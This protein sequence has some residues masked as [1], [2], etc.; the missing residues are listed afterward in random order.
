MSE[1]ENL[2]KA[3]NFSNYSRTIKN[4]IDL[5]KLKV[6]K[7]LRFSINGGMFEITPEFLIHVKSYAE[8]GIYQAVFLD[9]NDIPIKI[10]DLEEFYQEIL[11]KERNVLN[12]YYEEFEKIRMVRKLTDLI[13][14]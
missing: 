4:Q 1:V 10:E 7:Q 14:D 12:E 11:T 2:E 9:I 5:L 8:Q 13:D 6:K 3:Y